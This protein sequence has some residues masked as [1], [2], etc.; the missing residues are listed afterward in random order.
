VIPLDI[1]ARL[2]WSLTKKR[3]LNLTLSSYGR[4]YGGKFYDILNAI[5]IWLSYHF[6]WKKNWQANLLN[7]DLCF[8]GG[9][10]LIMDNHLDFPLK[11]YLLSHLARRS[12]VPYHLFAVGV[13][14]NWSSLGLRW[15]QSVVKNATTIHVRDKVS[16][17]RINHSFPHP[18]VSIVNDPAL[19]AAELYGYETLA[20]QKK[21]GINILNR[22]DFNEQRPPQSKVTP[23][24]WETFWINLAV[25]LTKQGFSVEY[26]TNGNGLDEELANRVWKK[27]ITLEPTINRAKRPYKPKELAR[28]IQN[29]SMVLASRLHATILAASYR[30]PT[31][32][33]AWDDKVTQFYN[34]MNCGERALIL[35]DLNVTPL[36]QALM[37]FNEGWDARLLE[38]KKSQIIA[39]LSRVLN[40]KGLD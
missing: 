23:Q 11:L 8:I 15:M 28:L 35:H 12:H 5:R 34:S 13:G 27:A 20:R 17:L 37:E 39:D 4:Q 2:G 22:V 16:L 7:A 24:D 33:I 10:K 31:I 21:V 29:Y 40:N 6:V 3:S 1:S 36:V 32:G 9:G 19:W 38:D 18:N 30:I 14:Q 26:F 25:A